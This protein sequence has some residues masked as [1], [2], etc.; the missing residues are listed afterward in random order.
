MVLWRDDINRRL[1]AAFDIKMAYPEVMSGIDALRALVERGVDRDKDRLEN[2]VRA[3]LAGQYEVDREIR[4]KQ[5]DLRNRL[6]DFFVDVSVS[7]GSVGQISSKRARDAFSFLRWLGLRTQR[8]RVSASLGVDYD[9]VGRHESPPGAADVILHPRSV[10]ALGKVV[11]E[12]AP[13]QGK[14]TLGQYV[15]QVHRARLLDKRED[16]GRLS[17]A[18][19]RAPVRL[20]I[21]VDLRDFA[22]WIGGRSPFTHGGAT[23]PPDLRT[24][25]GFLAAAISRNAGG[26][27][28]ASLGCPICLQVIGGVGCS[29]RPR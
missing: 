23:S 10:A 11:L 4:F 27:E 24:L 16:L 22:A 14:S 2:A 17:D 3:F 13:G 15:C 25:E 29:R 6:F 21:R 12:G 1:D 28:F 19:R 18:H 20:P 7:L 26:V 5:V 8:E 9:R